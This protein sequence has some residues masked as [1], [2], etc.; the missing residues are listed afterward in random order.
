MINNN[1]IIIITTT[2]PKNI[3]SSRRR[4]NLINKFSK[5]DIPLVFKDFIKK[6]KPMHEISY[7]MIVNSLSLFKNTKFDYAIICDDD[8]C[9]IDN[10][11]EELNK[12]V[13]LLSTN[14]RCLHLCP[15]YLWGRNFR[16]ISKISV[17]NPEYNMSGIPYDKSGRFY[18]NCD[19]KIYFDKKFWLGG[20]IAVLV[21]KNS[22]DS[23]LNDFI[24]EYNKFKENNDV[25]FTRILNSDDYICREPILGFENE[26]GGT[27]FESSN[28]LNFG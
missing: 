2:I 24:S 7:E 3:I 4:D 21:N 17:P 20:P 15:G 25:I 28:N 10:F 1:N 11:F 22:V 14:W 6:S 12:T 26:Q 16:D 19:S 8:F 5:W 23:F 18:M 13:N 9:P 27:T